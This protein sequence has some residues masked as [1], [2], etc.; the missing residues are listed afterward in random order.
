M[1]LKEVK[2]CRDC[3]E[4]F[5]LLGDL[6]A[7]AWGKD[8][9]ENASSLERLSDLMIDQFEDWGVENIEDE[10][11]DEYFD[12]KYDPGYTWESKEGVRKRL[13]YAFISTKTAYSGNVSS[14]G[15]E[16]FPINEGISDHKALI[17]G[18]EDEDFVLKRGY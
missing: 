5:V 9:S 13:D 2:A 18:L 12:Q 16:N 6:N 7:Y 14:A 17:I 15:I 10:D 8:E 3:D 1:I 4:D 11:L